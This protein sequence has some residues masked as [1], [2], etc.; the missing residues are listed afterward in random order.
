MPVTALQVPGSSPVT[1]VDRPVRVPLTTWA[2]LVTLKPTLGASGAGLVP[3]KSA[4]C[5]L[6]TYSSP[7]TRRQLPGSSPVT[8]SLRPTWVPVIPVPRR[9]WRLATLVGARPVTWLWSATYWVPV[10]CLPEPGSSPVTLLE[11][12]TITPETG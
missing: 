11:R 8:C 10:S 7:V 5:W 4:Y 1:L 2:L 9:V 3:Q 12:P 6:P